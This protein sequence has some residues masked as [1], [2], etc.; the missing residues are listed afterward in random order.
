MNTYKPMLAHSRE[1]PFDSPDWVYEAKWDGI[2]AITYIG[3]T[4][5][6]RSRNDKELLHKFP[7]LNELGDLS[8]N[9]ILDGE[10]IVIK[11]GIVDFQTVAK[12]NMIENSR[13]IEDL[14]KR[15]PAT[16][17]VFDILERDGEP[18]IDLPLS[19]RKRILKGAVK[20]GR[21]VVHSLTIE[22]KGINY[23]KAAEKQNLEGII[24]KKK[25]SSYQPGVRS[26]DWL[27]I[28]HVK[29]CDCVI[30]GYTLGKGARSSTFGALILGLYDAGKP[31]YVGRAGTG[32]SDES[33]HEIRDILDA[34]RVEELWF[35]DEDIPKGTVWVQPRHVAQIGYQE[36]T[37]TGRLRAPRFQGL[38]TEKTPALCSYSQVKPLK[39]EEY[40]A[41]RDFSKTPEPMGEEAVPQGNSFVIQEHH[42]RRTHWDLRLERDGVLRS[43]AVPKGAPM[44]TNERRLAVETENHP[45]EYGGFEGVIPK[46]QYGAGTVEIWDKG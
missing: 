31:V 41:K 8:S 6:V 4:L 14:Q 23:Y 20:E 33:L 17:V 19:E 21:H 38:R 45:L 10:I 39:L 40:Y 27:K 7:E 11:Q 46:G 35:S 26:S 9:V 5:S 28:K 42:A 36:I 24:A 32:F 15:H 37:Q 22:E 30:F 3:E 44:G 29:T 25:S 2:R 16:Y 18:L 34:E 1:K 12:R 13:E 43:W